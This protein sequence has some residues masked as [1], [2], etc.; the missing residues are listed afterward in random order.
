MNMSFL[1]KNVII[2]G[3]GGHLGPT[4]LS[5]F[6]SDPHFTTSILARNSST[7][8]FPSNLKV[9][10]VSDD[11]P[12]SELLEAF[13]DQDAIVSTIATASAGTQNKIIDAAV[14]AG[15]KR[16]VPSEFGSDTLNSKA[17]DIL[18]QYFAGKKAAVEYL[19]TKEKDGLTWTAFV[20]GPFFEL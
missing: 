8:T 10:R 14:K 5:A 13:K 19:K 3:A 16:F 20:T 11:Y 4:I 12:E 6:A 9:F 17:M 15:V 2:I 1:I 18:P 7:S